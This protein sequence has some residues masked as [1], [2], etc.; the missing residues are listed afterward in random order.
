MPVF[1][2]NESR[3]KM[4]ILTKHGHENSTWYSIIKHNSQSDGFII[5]TMMRR[6]IDSQI[7]KVT[8]RVQFYDNKNGG[9]L[10][11]YSL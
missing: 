3:I 4:V 6:F 9:M 2:K 8:N 10:E 7:S 5:K 11:Q 1:C